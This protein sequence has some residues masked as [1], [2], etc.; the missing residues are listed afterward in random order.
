MNSRTGHCSRA[1]RKSTYSPVKGLRVTSRHHYIS[2]CNSKLIG[3]DLGKYC[4]VSLPLCRDS[5]RGID[6][7]ISLYSHMRSLIGTDRCSFDVIANSDTKIA[8]IL[9]GLGLF[10]RKI[11]IIKHIFELIERGLIVPTIIFCLYP[12]LIDQSYIPGELMRLN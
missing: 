2:W 5:C 6:T 7:T 12:V 4:L 10:R 3:Y 8:A 1:A 9:P 11:I